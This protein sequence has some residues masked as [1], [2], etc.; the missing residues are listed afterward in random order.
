M[1]P[2]HSTDLIKSNSKRSLQLKSATA[3]MLCSNW[4]R[5]EKNYEHD[6]S[7][8]YEAAIVKVSH[9]PNAGEYLACCA[10]SKCSY[11]GPDE[12]RPLDVVFVDGNDIKLADVIQRRQPRRNDTHTTFEKLMKLDSF[13]QPGLMQREFCHFLTRCNCCELVMTRRMFERHECIGREGKGDPEII[14]LT[15]GDV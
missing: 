15:A 4:M 12:A 7:N 9:G 10:L 14:D 5:P 6:P 11:V 3:R 2:D 1:A 13:T 8:H